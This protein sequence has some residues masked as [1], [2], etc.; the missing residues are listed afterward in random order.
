MRS[1]LNF[2]PKW[3]ASLGL[4]LVIRL[5]GLEEDP[6][7]F[8]EESARSWIDDIQPE[9]VQVGMHVAI[10]SQLGRYPRGGQIGERRFVFVQAQYSSDIRHQPPGV[11]DG[12]SNG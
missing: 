10:S 8:R 7:R 1:S 11:R 2:Y 4:I 5:I 9:K 12:R 3:T 6:E